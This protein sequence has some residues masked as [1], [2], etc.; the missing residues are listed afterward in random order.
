MAVQERRVF[1]LVSR[2]RVLGLPFGHRLSSRRGAGADVVG[3]RPYRPGD[4]IAAIDWY[5]TAKLSA[6]RGA[7]EFVVRTYQA[8]EAPRVVVVCDRRPAMG[9][10]GPPFPWLSKPSALAEAVDLIVRSALA[11][12]SDVG[13]LDF[14][15]AAGE[16]YWLAPG[17]RG[18][19]W[20]IERRQ[21]PA[22]AFDAPDDGVAQSLAFLVRTRSD[23]PPG[24]FVF[25]LSDFLVPPPDAAWLDAVAQRWDVVPVVIQD[26][27]WEQSFPDAGS[28]VLPV[29]GAAGGHVRLVRLSRREARARRAA[30]EARLERLLVGLTALGLDP[31][32][33]GSARPDAV[34]DAFLAWAELRAAERRWR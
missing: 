5:A 32:L 19:Q 28:V 23:L 17:G 34:E 21:G 29:V 11:A 20:L 12:R 1:P 6:A 15:G 26:P 33:L 18:E 2:R 22:T 31:V 24:S 8:D 10:Y 4:P 14:A 9:I 16:P 27:V 13:S 3:S 7:D 25:V 30:H